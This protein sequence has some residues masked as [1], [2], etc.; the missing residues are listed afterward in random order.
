MS[1]FVYVSSGAEADELLLPLWKEQNRVDG[2]QPSKKSWAFI[3]KEENKVIGGITGFFKDDWCYVKELILDLEYRGGGRG[4]SLL[5]KAEDYAKKQGCIG[6][7]L[8][9]YSYQ[10]RDF[11]IKYG[12]DEV[13]IMNDMPKDH[14]T[15]FLQKV[16]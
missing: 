4:S 9:T 14:S 12:L 13:L 11:Y 7:Y 2:H 10:A 16:F 15:H 8:K 1:E 6:L 3:L 5:K